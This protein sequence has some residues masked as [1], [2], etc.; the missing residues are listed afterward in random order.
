V[1]TVVD[2]S[3]G[4]PSTPVGRDIE[5]VLVTGA[6]ASC[7]F[8]QLRRFPLIGEWSRA[9][10]EK[11]SGRY[12]SLAF[13]E[14]IDLEGADDGPEFER[15]L[16][17]FLRQIQAF[18]EIA[19]IVKASL[20][21]STTPQQFKM[22]N[23]SS[24]VLEGWYN[25]T[26]NAIAD[27]L[28]A[29][30][31]TLYVL[32]DEPGINE[33]TAPR[34]FGW[35]FEELR[36]DHH[37]SIVVA[38]TNYDLVAETVLDRLGYPIN[39]GRPAQ[40]QPSSEAE[41]RVERLVAGVHSYVPVLHLHGRIGWY[42]RDDGLV[43]ELQGANYSKQWGTPVVMWPDDEKDASSYIATP[44][45]DELW[46]QFREALRRARKVLVLGHSL[47][48]QFLV[49]ALRENV[50]ARRLAITVYA[51]S[52]DELESD[53]NRPVVESIQRTFGPVMTVPM[54]FGEARSGADQLGL[55]MQDVNELGS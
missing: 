39:W 40:L 33:F 30:N 12:E 37:S 15:R 45:I 22:I 4:S 26:A 48:D 10:H 17:A 42:L 35:L 16:G 44:I 27:L 19:P 53:Q 38:T 8:G 32:F 55:W 49:Q 13:R 54:V 36:V 20:Q 28:E 41:L 52:L 1:K 9:L 21:L 18:R 46:N 23:G 24:S 14:M 11:L 31:E 43:R 34:A 7:A 2:S 50:P 47:H 29:L 6:G 3:D 51:E 25:Q 5:L